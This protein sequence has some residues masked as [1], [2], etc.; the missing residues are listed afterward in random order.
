MCTAELD[1]EW[2]R[3]NKPTKSAKRDIS[4]C[5]MSAFFTAWKPCQHSMWLQVANVATF[6]KLIS[7]NNTNLLAIRIIPTI[8]H[9]WENQLYINPFPILDI[10]NSNLSS[11][12]WLKAGLLRTNPSESA[13]FRTFRLRRDAHMAQVTRFVGSLMNFPKVILKGHM[14]R[15]DSY[16]HV[17]KAVE[18]L[19]GEILTWICDFQF[20][21]Q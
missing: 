5:H 16:G 15:I 21:G 2:L 4:P 12:T 14:V 7:T 20:V 18:D 11:N 17:T 19:H 3:W 9:L 8:N 6:H 13:K 1:F 10:K